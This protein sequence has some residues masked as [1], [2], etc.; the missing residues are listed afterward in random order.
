MFVLKY[1]FSP[2]LHGLCSVSLF[3]FCCKTLVALP[4]ELIRRYFYIFERAF[5]I[6]KTIYNVEFFLFISKESSTFLLNW[7]QHLFQLKYK[8]ECYMC[9]RLG[10]GG[11]RI[12]YLL[13]HVNVNFKKGI[14]YIDVHFASSEFLK[15]KWSLWT[16]RKVPILS[17]P[18]PPRIWSFIN[19]VVLLS[20]ILFFFF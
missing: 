8:H 11:L 17:L 16:F 2:F 10:C 4:Y 7:L 6:K 12:C 13:V 15:E 3:I 5:I 9:I 19:Q 14:N 18:I 20:I 1:W